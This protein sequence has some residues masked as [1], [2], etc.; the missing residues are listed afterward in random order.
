LYHLFFRDHFFDSEAR[1]AFKRRRTTNAA[2]GVLKDINDGVRGQP[3]VRHYHKDD[4]SKIK[5]FNA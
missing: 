3:A 1:L 4:F 2:S 5:N